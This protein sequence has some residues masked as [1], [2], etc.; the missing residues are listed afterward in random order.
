MSQFCPC[1]GSYRNFTQRRWGG[2]SPGSRA[3]GGGGAVEGL[4]QRAVVVRLAGPVDWLLRRARV[5]GLVYLHTSPPATGN[6][7]MGDSR[8]AQHP[9]TDALRHLTVLGTS[10]MR[11]LCPGHAHSRIVCAATLE[12]TTSAAAP[13]CPCASFLDM[14]CQ[15]WPFSAP[16]THM[17]ALPAYAVVC[18]FTYHS[19]S[20]RL[21]TRSDGMVLCSPQGHRVDFST[22]LPSQ[23]GL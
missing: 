12:C 10:C 16:A 18:G 5:A 4:R 19:P 11:A 13:G 6:R 3:H 22:F 8:G 2:V 9:T 15:F 17:H 20:L 7:E 14:P 21:S 1:R 23:L